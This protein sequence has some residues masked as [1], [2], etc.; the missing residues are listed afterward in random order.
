MEIPFTITVR[1]KAS[2]PNATRW[3]EGEADYRIFKEAYDI[4]RGYR[5]MWLNGNLVP[6]VATKFDIDWDEHVLEVP[7]YD[8]GWVYTGDA[9]G[10]FTIR[11]KQGNCY[12]ENGFSILCVDHSTNVDL[13][14]CAKDLLDALVSNYEGKDVSPVLLAEQLER[15]NENG[16]LKQAMG[17]L[18]QEKGLHVKGIFEKLEKEYKMEQGIADVICEKGSSVSSLLGDGAVGAAGLGLSAEKGDTIKLV[19]SRSEENGP[20]EFRNR[21]KTVVPLDLSVFINDSPLPG[22]KLKIPVII[23]IPL[24]EGMD[25]ANVKVFHI[26]DGEEKPELVRSIEAG[27]N[28][29]FVADE[30]STYLL[31][32]EK[33][34]NKPQGDGSVSA[35]GTASGS[36]ASSSGS[37]HSSSDSSGSAETAPQGTWQ[38]DQTGWWYRNPDGTYPVNAWV[39]LPY[40]QRYDWYHFDERGYMQTGWFLDTDGRWYYLNPVSNGTLGAM[41]TGWKQIEDDWYYFN[42]VSDGYKGAMYAN[43]V[44]PDGYETDSQGR[45]IQ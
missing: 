22:G 32:E 24:P 12:A 26:H 31:A 17:D 6:S 36:H 30:F 34:Q 25:S 44:T 43:T 7:I 35:G 3:V 20:E 10:K 29:S 27:N 8:S 18:L 16:V 39:R 2:P 1:T 28:V 19:V 9:E 42:E 4:G 40:Y 41:V 15:V 21:Y 37:D 14:E 45:W 38:Q 23:T 33:K 11:T 5:K 13:L